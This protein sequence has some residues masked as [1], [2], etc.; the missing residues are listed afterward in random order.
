MAQP[1]CSDMEHYTTT[2]GTSFGENGPMPVA[3]ISRGGGGGAYFKNW[4]QII[5]VGMIQR[6]NSEDKRAE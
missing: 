6:A 5:N 1:V 2:I 3:R 4:D